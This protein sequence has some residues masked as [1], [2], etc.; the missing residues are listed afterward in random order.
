MFRISAVFPLNNLIISPGLN[1][2]PS[3][4]F[5]TDGTIA[6]TLIGS[7]NS[8]IA[9]ITPKTVQPPHLSN[10]ISSIFSPGF[11]DIPPVSKVTAFP[12]SKIGFCSF[13]PFLYSKIMNLGSFLLP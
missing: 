2:S 11:N 1:D 7:F 10:F 3:G 12:T 5:S 8:E 6:T 4:M 13:F 9:F